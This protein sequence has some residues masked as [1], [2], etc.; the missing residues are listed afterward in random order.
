[1]SDIPSVV[2]SWVS[3][4]GTL[5]EGRATAGLA[6][7]LLRTWATTNTRL[8]ADAPAARTL[9]VRTEDLDAAGPRLAAFC[10]VDPASLRPGLRWNV[11]PD[12]Y[13][14]LADVP[15]ELM[16]S[17]AERWC[18]PLMEEHWGPE[19]RALVA[20]IPAAL[21]GASSQGGGG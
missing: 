9:L 18:A 16:V 19:W 17:E 3:V 15:P 2:R 13:G 4:E 5:R 8:L 11:A 7:A 6:V 1:M 20:R 10:G 21:G 14:V 12:R